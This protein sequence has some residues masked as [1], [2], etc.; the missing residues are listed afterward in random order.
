MN[1]DRQILPPTKFTVALLHGHEAHTESALA[2]FKSRSAK[3]ERS[4]RVHLTI[5]T[6]ERLVRM[7]IPFYGPNC[8]IAIYE[9]EE[10]ESL[11]ARSTLGAI[12]GWTPP[13]QPLVLLIG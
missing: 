11:I 3:P 8:S 13:H 1:L 4:L 6:L 5:H 9:D 12:E 10:R 7:L 2:L